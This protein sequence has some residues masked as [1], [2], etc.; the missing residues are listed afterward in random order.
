[1]KGT[2]IMGST[3]LEQA[4]LKVKE[5]L[6]EDAEFK[7]KLELLKSIKGFGDLLKAFPALWWILKA[8]VPAVEYVYQEYHLCSE[9]ERIDVAAKLL[10]DLIE[11]KGWLSVFEPFDNMMFKLIISS[12]V[13]ALNDKFG[14][15]WFASG[16]KTYSAANFV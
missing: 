3:N 16:E 10:D 4:I 5:L 15:A 13:Q 6:F 9:E 11:F 1:M 8:L 2:K 7:A 12:A 14:K